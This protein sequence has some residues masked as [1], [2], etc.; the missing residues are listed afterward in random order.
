MKN[1]FL[2]GLTTLGLTALLFT[3]CSKVPQVEIDAAN[4]AIEAAKTAG[5][6]QYQYEGFVAL[7]D[8]MK[9][10]MVN[11]ENQKSKFIKNYSDAKTQ[12]DAV[13]VMAQSVLQNTLTRIE[14]VKVEVQNTTAEVKTL[15]ETNRQL[16]KEAPKGKE[17]ATA[18]LAI[19][20]ELNV[21]ETT[22]TNAETKFSA[23]EYLT[24]L[25]MVKASKE[26]A[27]SINTELT[28]VIAKYKSNVKGRK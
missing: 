15:I 21:I 17:G 20:E 14:E 27:T 4:T 1:K 25:D 23:N 18:L 8:S 6:E 13:T 5:A 12:L 7:Q 26:K 10:V 24:A 3:S 22:L 16:I 9:S 2:I 19:K 28:E 11:I